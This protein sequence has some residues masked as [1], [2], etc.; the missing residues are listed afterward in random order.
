[1]V[2]AKRLVG[3]VLV[4]LSLLAV[5]QTIREVVLWELGTRKYSEESPGG[6][7]VYFAGRRYE[8]RDDQPMDSVHSQAAHEGTIQPL[9]DGAPVGPPS[10]AM[11]RRALTNLGRYHGW[12][13][14]WIFRER[15][16]GEQSLWLARRIQPTATDSPRF[17]V[18]V[19]SAGG[20]SRTRILRGW[21]L[22]SDYRHYRAT[23]FMRGGTWAI[24]LALG[25]FVFFPILFLIFPVG[26]LVVGILLVRS[27]SKP[28][29]SFT[30]S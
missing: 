9:V 10:R 22:G 21:Q 14:A 8:V 1:M 29:T 24:P 25:S 23:Q 6:P 16:N 5:A 3:A 4:G 19:V 7:T 18:T 15:P 20:T 2:K 28:T 13:D 17:E 30:A 27:R 26:T 12:Y 11:V